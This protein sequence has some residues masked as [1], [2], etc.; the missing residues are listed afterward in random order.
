[1]L[2]GGGGGDDDDRWVE[3]GEEGGGGLSQQQLGGVGAVKGG[4]AL[5]RPFIYLKVKLIK[6]GIFGL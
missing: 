5:D 2:R 6:L 3:G 4:V 1:M